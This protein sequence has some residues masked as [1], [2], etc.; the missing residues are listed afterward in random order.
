VRGWLLLLLCVTPLLADK[1]DGPRPDKSDCFRL[2]VSYDTLAA[3]L[4]GDGRPFADEPSLDGGLADLEDRACRG[5]DW[6]PI[7]REVVWS[8]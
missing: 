7:V 2:P 3:V 8:G 5:W 4:T 6:H 1:D